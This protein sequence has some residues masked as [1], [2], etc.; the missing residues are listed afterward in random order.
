[1][2]RLCLVYN[3]MKE[4][5][6]NLRQRAS[7]RKCET[8]GARA[9]GQRGGRE[10]AT[11]ERGAR[12]LLERARDV[13]FAALQRGRATARA[14]RR[15]GRP[16]QAA[17]D[18]GPCAVLGFPSL[19]RPRQYYELDICL[20]ERK[21]LNESLPGRAEPHGSK[22]SERQAERGALAARDGSCSC[23]CTRLH[24]AEHSLD[25]EGSVRYRLLRC[26]VGETTAG[27]EEERYR[28]ILRRLDLEI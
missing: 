20:R 4:V 22:R 15:A 2:Y 11:I 8:R 26:K 23:S 9:R 13:T 17:K 7:E 21:L 18:G 5:S 19:A 3:A 27:T 1:V 24:S 14:G 6:L 12:L 25:D 10:A 28:E 16:S